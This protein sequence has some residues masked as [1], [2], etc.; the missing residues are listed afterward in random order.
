M[1]ALSTNSGEPDITPCLTEVQIHT[2]IHTYIHVSLFPVMLAKRVRPITKETCVP[3]LKDKPCRSDQ[4]LNRIRKRNY[5]NG[6]NYVIYVKYPCSCHECIQCTGCTAPLI[7]T[8]C[9]T[10][11]AVR[12]S[13]PPMSLLVVL[14][15]CQ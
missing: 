8:L 11:T 5:V 10:Q 4:M 13:E 3:N 6:Y 7:L 12:R 14:A 2:Y 1:T 15:F 9:H